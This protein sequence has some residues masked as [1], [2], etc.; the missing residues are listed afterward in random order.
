[1]P[2]HRKTSQA[3]RG[4]FG[5]V[6]PLNRKILVR[7]QNRQ[8]G[9]LNKFFKKSTDPFSQKGQFSCFNSTLISTLTEA[10]MFLHRGFLI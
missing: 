3:C 9:R 8:K 1:M 4:A 7:R 2:S 6:I 5:A 10:P